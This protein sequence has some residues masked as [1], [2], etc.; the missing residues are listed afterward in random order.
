MAIDLARGVPVRPIGIHAH[1][2]DRSNWALPMGHGPR[3]LGLASV[4]AWAGV[5]NHR[6]RRFARLAI[7]DPEVDDCPVEQDSFQL[8][9]QDRRRLDV[10]LSERYGQSRSYFDSLIR[11][12]AVKV[13]GRL[14]KKSFKEF[15]DGDVVDVSFLLDDSSLDLGPE[16]IPLEILH[17]DEHLMIVNKP[18]GLVVHPAPGNWTGTLVN[19]V[20][21][22]LGA[23][24]A[25]LPSTE[26]G[27]A[28][29]RPGIVHRLDVGT[30]GVIAVAKTA[31]AF[32]GLSEAFARRKVRKTYLAV[33]VGGRGYFFG[34]SE[35][36][37]HLVDLA[38]GR[39]RGDRRKIC[40]LPEEC[41]G[42]TAES[43]VRGLARDQDL[44]LLEVKPRTGRT[45][46][47]RIHLAEEHTPILGDAT[48]GWAFMNRRYAS[49]AQRPM[50]HAY[51]LAFEHPVFKELVEF[52]A[53]MPAD[54]RRLLQRMT[55]EGFAFPGLTC[56]ATRDLAFSVLHGHGHA[57]PC[58]VFRRWQEGV[59]LEAY[60][61]EAQE[62]KLLRQQMAASK[63]PP[64]DERRDLVQ[65]LS[66]SHSCQSPGAE[67]SCEELQRRLQAVQATRDAA[68]QS[69]EQ[70]PGRLSA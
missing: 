17:E 38:V 26:P 49:A 52:R 19:A 59:E 16:A 10:L 3:R 66:L 18:P 46:Q 56:A 13:N 47:I 57:T 27:K 9:G 37:G 23:A 42:R 8:E 28:S 32:T 61:Q 29:A 24:A 69:A 41:G 43:L 54:M 58:N 21:H 7:A 39:S 5:Q 68:L 55:P 1:A 20:L 62:L 36:G 14:R 35:G 25:E 44:L 11:K 48:Y 45:H 60:Q 4:L 53:P 34:H 40:A 70:E 15:R 6:R 22:H 50:L 2:A 12:G 33:A 64:R 67:L 63:A 65:S 31:Q 51:H 30:S